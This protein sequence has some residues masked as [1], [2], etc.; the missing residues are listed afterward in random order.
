MLAACGGSDD[1]MIENGPARGGTAGTGA[2]PPPEGET[3]TNEN[4]PATDG[5]TNSAIMVAGQLYSPEGYFT[6]VGA[7]PAV[8]EGEVDFAAFREFGNANATA[9]AGYIFVEQD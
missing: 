7:F 5:P 4:P 8:P 6:Y 1:T 9:H 3:P 2:E